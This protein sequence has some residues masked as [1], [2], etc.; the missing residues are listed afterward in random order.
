MARTLLDVWETL[1]AGGAAPFEIATLRRLAADLPDD[2]SV[3]HGVHWTRLDHGYSVYGEIDFIVVGSQG[4]IVLIEQKGGPLE[5]TPTG[6]VKSY[7]DKQKSVTLQIQRSIDSL[8]S[9]FKQGHAGQRLALDYLLYCPD[10]R[11]MS[12]ATAGL[13]RSASSTPAPPIGSRPS[14]PRCWRR[15][16]P[17]PGSRWRRCTRSSQMSWSSPSTRARR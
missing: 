13:L 10:H 12:P 11:V 3:F 15:W 9:R 6:L 4:Q 7:R 16:L 2:C 14:S 17:R 8:Q 5:E 1:E